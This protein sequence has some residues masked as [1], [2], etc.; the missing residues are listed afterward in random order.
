MFMDVYQQRRSLYQKAVNE[1]VPES[2]VSADHTFK[3]AKNVCGFRE[4]DD[5][6]V[7][8]GNKLFL[9]MDA[10]QYIVG[11]KLTKN[12]GH[13]DIKET[14][15]EVRICNMKIFLHSSSYLFLTIYLHT[16]PSS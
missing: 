2:C 5:V 9:V 6:L 4:E 8:T 15:T 1:V 10:N 16:V 14:L 3:I 12:V 7:K 11:W 13:E